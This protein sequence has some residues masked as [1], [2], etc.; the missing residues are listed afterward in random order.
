[1]LVNQNTNVQK[2]CCK[3]PRFYLVLLIPQHLNAN[4]KQAQFTLQQ[5]FR[6]AYTSLTNLI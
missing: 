5:Q 2:S 3:V 6:E 1:M 4:M